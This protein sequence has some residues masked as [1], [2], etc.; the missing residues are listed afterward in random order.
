MTYKEL[1]KDIDSVIKEAE[2][3]L[4]FKTKCLDIAE[5]HETMTYFICG[6]HF[7]IKAVEDKHL[8][9]VENG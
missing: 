3:F 6:K 2:K 8:K 4:D 5:H 9:E 7:E 1:R